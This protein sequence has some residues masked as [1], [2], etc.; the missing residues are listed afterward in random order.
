MYEWFQRVLGGDGSPFY[1]FAKSLGG[2]MSGAVSGYNLSPITLILLPI[3]GT[4]T[5]GFIT[6]GIIL[7]FGL[8]GVSAYFYLD[9]R[10]SLNRAVRICLSI[11]FSMMLFML[12]QAPNPMWL[13]DVV[14]LPL[15]MYGIFLLVTKGRFV[16]FYITLLLCII[17]SW[18]NGYMI[19]LFAILFY[20]FE[21]YLYKHDGFKASNDSRSNCDSSD[22]DNRCSNDKAKSDKGDNNSNN[23]NN[24]ESKNCNN[25]SDNDSSSSLNNRN[26]LGK[27]KQNR[28][29]RYPCRFAIIFTLAVAASLIVL[30]PT[31]LLL[32]GGKGAIPPGLFSLDTRFVF[33]DV[34]RSL[35]PGIYEKE[36][37]PQ[38]YSGLFVLIGVVYFMLSKNVQKRVKLATVIFIALMLVSAWLVVL[39]RV[40]L[41]FRDGNSFYCRFSFLHSFLFVFVAAM[42][43]NNK[44]KLEFRPL[45]VAALAVLVLGGIITLDDQFP[46][47]RFTLIVIAI[48][49][50]VPMSLYLLNKYNSKLTRCLL[51]CLLVALIS[52]EALLVSHWQFQF[53]TTAD[54]QSP[55]SRY[56]SYFMDG[57]EQYDELQ[58]IDNIHDNPYRVGKTYNYMTP[59]RRLSSNEGF[60]YGYS[61][62]AQYDSFYDDRV[63]NVLARLGYAPDRGFRTTYNDS[64][65]PA[66]SLI[67][68]KYVASQEKPRGF[69]ESELTKTQ[70][71]NRFYTNPYALPLAF[72]ADNDI[73][74]NISFNKDPFDYQN[75]FYSALLGRD[76]KIFT[77]VQSRLLRTETDAITNTSSNASANTSNAVSSWTWEI[78]SEDTSNLY[79]Y[80]QYDWQ[81]SVDLYDNDDYLYIYLDDW[82][83]GIFPL[84]DNVGA[85]NKKTVTLKGQIPNNA[86]DLV[87]TSY[88][89]NIK[90]LEGATNALKKEPLNFT[91]FRDGFVSG[92]FQADSDKLLFTTIPY[93]SGWE[94]KIN[95]Q[96]VKP[97]IVQDAFIGLELQAGLNKIE[98][99]Y[100][101]PGFIVG[102]T[103]FAASLVT[104]TVMAIILRR[105]ENNY[106][107]RRRENK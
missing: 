90:A 78:L 73:L 1:A 10:F 23:S 51:S 4:N 70:E 42:A 69:K 47:L 79:G 59:F 104:M 84:S 103:L 101:A 28:F 22:Y 67:G 74:T 45:L 64:I 98:M 82:S 2:N 77:K 38:L 85:D 3:F 63:Q 24:S 25:A 105:R 88:R 60:V 93:D 33:T 12:S 87:F 92:N 91:D 39:D 75:R 65:L 27:L 35:F 13:D 19:C 43:F 16:L 96:V 30:L 9:R 106:P 76:T 11:C 17:I 52:F 29:L 18:Y 56:E 68:I 72:V 26:K 86:T 20:L 71:G 46:R 99:R 49:C 34:L 14:L 55:F 48:C 107:M 54:D 89:L 57:R 21:C 94:I 81:L 44:H 58:A 6:A 8:A 15:V 102:A 83:H 5:I 40:W 61:Q 66:D 41:G 53:R 95:D 32:L 97:H 80:F 50:L 62:V 100:V 37:L 36:Y 31:A 7:K